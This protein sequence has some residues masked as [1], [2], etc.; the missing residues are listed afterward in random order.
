M[1]RI[2]IVEDDPTARDVL[3]GHLRRYAAERRLEVDLRTFADG[4]QLIDGY[5]A[6]Y[7]IL[8]LD[9]EMPEVGG[10]EAAHHI[11]ETDPDVII[12]F[13]TNM[14]Q[15]A[16]KG[17]EVDALSFLL[18]PVHYFSLE[19]ELDRSIGR[20]R[21]RDDQTLVVNVAGALTRIDLADI[22]YLESIRHRIIVHTRGSE[23]SFTGTLKVLEAELDGKG[24]YRCNNPYLVNLRHVRSV[25]PTT[26]TMTG[27][28]ELQV[29]RPRKR[30]FMDALAD[31]MGGSRQ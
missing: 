30:G 7:D 18:K 24:F 13:V 6:D 25:Q 4:A 26:C 10:L 11:R 27:G 19:H 15:Y 9:I 1:I 31:H 17:Y 16:I 20:L 21:T 29:S 2:G 3:V 8:L 5:R 28:V 22:V 23:L 14:A 12:V